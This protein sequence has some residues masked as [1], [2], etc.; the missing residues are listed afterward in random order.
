MA[1]EEEEIAT[2]NEESQILEE[3]TPNDAGDNIAPD[4]LLKLPLSRVKSIM[5]S[6]PDVTLASQDAVVALAK[7]TELFIQLISKDASGSTMQGKRKTLQRKDLDNVM[8]RR[9]CY[10][11]LDGAID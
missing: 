9:D 10:L 6:D 1:G 8:D 2:Q 5:K 3:N 4:R 7:A 11:F